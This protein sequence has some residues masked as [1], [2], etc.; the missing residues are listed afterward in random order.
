M[1][2]ESIYMYTVNLCDQV[3]FEKLIV[4]VALYY[5]ESLLLYFLRNCVSYR[6]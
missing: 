5:F 2:Y 1:I 6:K 4:S 3:S